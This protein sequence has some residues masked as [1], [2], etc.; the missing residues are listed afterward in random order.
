MEKLKELLSSLYTRRCKTFKFTP[1]GLEKFVSLPP[2]SQRLMF[3]ILSKLKKGNSLDAVSVVSD[4]KDFGFDLSSNFYR[5]RRLIEDTGL[6]YSDDGRIYVN[7]NFIYYLTS[8]QL[9]YFYVKCG[10][11]KPP[12]AIFAGLKS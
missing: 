6:I 12:V 2:R 11:K 1:I 10:V 3:H 4:Y 5:Y 8:S 7:P 9:D